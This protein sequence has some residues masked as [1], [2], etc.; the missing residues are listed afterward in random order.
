ME[1]GG[2]SKEGREKRTDWNSVRK[3]GESDGVLGECGVG[4]VG[5]ETGHIVVFEEGAKKRR[6]RA[7]GLHLVD[8][9]DEVADAAAGRFEGLGNPVVSAAS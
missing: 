6:V 5:W 4:C 3:H 2:W 7:S 8:A 9:I 1:I